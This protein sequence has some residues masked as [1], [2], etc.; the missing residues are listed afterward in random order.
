MNVADFKDW[1]RTSKAGKQVVYGRSAGDVTPPRDIMRAAYDA[2][3]RGRVLLV[4]KRTGVTFDSFDLK[5]KPY[6]NGDG[7]FDYIAVKV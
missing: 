7:R 3:K 6:R 5:G 4:Q 1:V 2:Y